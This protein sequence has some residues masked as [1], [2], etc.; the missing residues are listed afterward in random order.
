M[1]VFYGWKMVGAAAAIQTLQSG[2]LQ[3]AIGAYV[4]VLSEERGWS[5]TALSGGAAIQ[6]LEAALLGPLL[7]WI[8]D[9]FGAQGMIRAGVAIMSVGF[10]AFSQIN[11]LEGFYGALVVIAI[12]GSFCGFFPLTVALVQWF[13]RNRARAL[14]LMGM[15][16]ALGG[17][18]VPLVALAMESYGWRATAIGSA[19]LYALV[20]WP[21]ARVIRSRPE[22][23]GATVDGRPATTTGPADAFPATLDAAA[24]HTRQALEFTLRQAVR[25]SAFW[26]ISFG[27]AFALLAVY[28]VNVHAITHIRQS[29]GYTIAE[30]GS[31]ISLMTMTQIGGV[32]LGSVIGDRFEKRYVAAGCMQAHMIAL[33][34]LTYASGIAMLIGFAMLHGAAWGLRGPFMQAIRAD[35]FGRTAIG[36][37]LG[38][39]TA[40]IALGQVAGPMI[41]GIAADV[42]G[43]YT[44]GFT[45]LAL[46]AGAGSIFFLAARKPT[47]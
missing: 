16:T 24:K 10:L 36:K 28:A 46:L 1:K 23:H 26:L 45:L 21:L 34:L 5:K 14:S 38:L 41:A 8:V 4:A 30:A 33:L 37:I 7:G 6:S 31:I 20:G 9:R 44:V 15:G 39:S 11:T 47:L 32:L 42:T 27:H 19:V 40:I 17:L 12:G 2:L 13:E 29:L 22:D 18:C 43:K 25:T 3:Q 35:Y